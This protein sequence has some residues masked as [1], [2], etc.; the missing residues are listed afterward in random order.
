MKKE[1]SIYYISWKS[2]QLLIYYNIIMVAK[3]FWGSAECWRCLYTSIRDPM[4]EILEACINR[5]LQSFYQCWDYL[6]FVVLKMNFMGMGLS[7]C[8]EGEALTFALVWHLW[9]AREARRAIDVKGEWRYI[10]L[11]LPACRWQWKGHIQCYSLLAM[12]LPVSI[13]W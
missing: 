12:C 3:P 5:S 8:K 4:R 9:P 10:I 13:Q 2:L 1:K 6:I 11:S 7:G